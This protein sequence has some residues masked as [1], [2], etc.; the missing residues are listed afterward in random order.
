M[1]C[2]KYIERI[3]IVHYDL[4]CYII[5]IALKKKQVLN[6]IYLFVREF[7]FQRVPGCVILT[8]GKSILR[9]ADSVIIFQYFLGFLNS[10]LRL[11]KFSSKSTL[12]GLTMISS[13][14]ALK[15]MQIHIEILIYIRKRSRSKV[16]LNA[17]F[18]FLF[19]ASDRLSPLHIC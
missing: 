8:L 11:L 9:G 15:V 1:S 2:R 18:F 13:Q 14:I 5:F 10:F 19:L 12:D 17:S 7:R 3:I 16:N 6:K 4:P